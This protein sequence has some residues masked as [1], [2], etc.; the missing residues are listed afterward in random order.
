MHTSTCAEVVIQGKT[1]STQPKIGSKGGEFQ[2]VIPRGEGSSK[3]S[4]STEEEE[5]GMLIDP[6]GVQND[7]MKAPDQIPNMKIGEQREWATLFN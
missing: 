7:A 6:G 5:I 3:R 4:L 2:I 1:L